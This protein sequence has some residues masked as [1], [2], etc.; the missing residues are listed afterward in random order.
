[1]PHLSLDVATMVLEGELPPRVLV[2]I[3]YDHI[4]ELCPDCR[5]A[6][7]A[8]QGMP[9]R[10]R[11]PDAA[12]DGSEQY[13]A[14]LDGVGRRLGERL[15]TAQVERR[16]ARRDLAELLT[17]PAEEREPRIARARTRFRS[18]HLAELLIASS[19]EIVR[20][21]PAEAIALVDLVPLVLAR[22]VGAAER[23][24][25]PSLGVLALVHR[26]N[27]LRVGGDLPAADRT[28]AAVR[29]RLA[30]SLLDDPALHGEVCARESSLRR[31]Q[32][33]LDEA[34]TLSDRAVLLARLG[35]DDEALAEF[36]IQ[37]AEIA[38]QRDDSTAAAEC[39]REAQSLVEATGNRH[40][41]ACAVGTLALLE[42]DRGEHA[43]ADELVRRHR[44]LL[45]GDGSSWS[46]VR[47]F[48]LEGRIAHGLGRLGTAEERLLA[49]HRLCV[50][51]ELEADA[52][53][54]ALELAVLYAEQGRFAEVR[55]LARRI[56]PALSAREVH[57][58]ATA[59]LLLF[60]QAVAAERITVE[61]M[62]SVRDVLGRRGSSTPADPQPS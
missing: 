57:R 6:L 38:R 36:L 47:V 12:A 39:L 9:A 61:A 53:M 17:L 1:M 55:Q 56:Q 30:A 45:V 54:M 16:R 23:S 27:A 52:A 21:D 26:G 31:D 60:Q 37:R 2:R 50:A 43:A 25:A 41:L 29:E 22:L 20:N 3:L 34:E 42:C 14:A 24:A 18:R 33:R 58:E 4:K 44:E 15:R 49:A 19:R 40:L 59:A 35:H 7:E 8:V 10:A 13:H 48:A 62:R 46:L 11:R 5:R 28:F 51:E 32:R